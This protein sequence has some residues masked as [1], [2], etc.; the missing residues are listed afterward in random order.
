METL[1]IILAMITLFLLLAVLGT[2]REAIILREHVAALS[3]LIVKPPA[4][5]FLHQPLPDVIADRLSLPG[6]LRERSHQSH[7]ILFFSAGCNGCAAFIPRLQEVVN[8]DLIDSSQLSCIVS[9]SSENE[10]V[11][12]LARAVCGTA[13]LDRQGQLAKALE[14]KMTPVQ[15]A[16]ST[17][18]LEVVDYTLGGDVE[19]IRQQLQEQPE[20]VMAF[21]H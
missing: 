2:M 16:I 18:T 5:S 19:W 14:V 1:F 20:R 10:P 17:H 11:Y 13:I 3:Q 8:E 6:R 12:Q 21:R 7:V 4:P 9:A 15:F